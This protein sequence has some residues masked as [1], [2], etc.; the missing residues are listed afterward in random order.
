MANKRPGKKRQRCIVCNKVMPRK[1]F[2]GRPTTVCEACRDARLAHTLSIRGQAAIAF[3]SSM[4]RTKIPLDAEL[5]ITE[6]PRRNLKE[7]EEISKLPAAPK[8]LVY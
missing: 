3:N 5:A 7:M 1:V 2:R 6:S 4:P 8:Q